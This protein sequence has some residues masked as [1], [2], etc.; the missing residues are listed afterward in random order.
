MTLTDIGK[1]PIEEEGKKRV[2]LINFVRNTKN[3][4]LFLKQTLTKWHMKHV[5]NLPILPAPDIQ[6]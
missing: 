3:K 1:H 6:I 2:N 5:S 4:T